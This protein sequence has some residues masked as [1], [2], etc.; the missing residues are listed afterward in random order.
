MLYIP[1]LK[2]T[3]EDHVRRIIAL[4]LSMGLGVTYISMI[5]SNTSSEIPSTTLFG[6][7]PTPAYGAPAQV[8]ST[9]VIGGT[10]ISR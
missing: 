2:E 5:L 7:L 4:I 3:R 1:S 10:I 8:E 6:P 9:D